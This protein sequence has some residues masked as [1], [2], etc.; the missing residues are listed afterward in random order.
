MIYWLLFIFL[1]GV[2]VFIHE[3]GHFT[4]AKLSG[5]KVER[6]AIGFGPV[7]IG[8][9]FGETEYAIC[10]LPLGGY[11]KMFGE[12]P[13]EEASDETIKQDPRSFAAK[14]AYTRIAVAAM[15]PI[16][17]LIL[18]IFIYM[19]TLLAIPTI[20]SEI[21]S[22]IPQSAASKAGLKAGDRVL[23]ING[24]KV[25]KWTEVDRVIADNPA[26]SLAV[27]V[28]REGSTES[29]T[30]TPK[31][32]KI[33]TPFGDKERGIAGISYERYRPV[34]GIFD[35][36][37]SAAK[38]GLQSG[39]VIVSV[40]GMTVESWRE[41]QRQFE[42]SPTPQ[43]IKVERFGENLTF[44]AP[45]ASQPK[46]ELTFN[47]P[48]RAS[49]LMSAGLETGD[50]YIRKVLPKSI[51]EEKGLKEGDRLV[52]LNG[53]ELASWYQFQKAIQG[54]KGEEISIGLLRTGKPL[55]INLVPNSIS[56][57]NDLTQETKKR[58]QLGVISSIVA[59]EP[60]GTRAPYLKNPLYALADGIQTTIE[61]ST[62]VVIG[63]SKIFTGQIELKKSLGGP[64]T[65]FY[66]AGDSYKA[67]GWHYFFRMMAMLSITLGL[68]N[69]LPIPVLD[70][71]HIF[72]FTI[73]ALKGSP[74]SLRVR[75]TAQQ[76]GM[77]LLLGLILL[78]FYVDISRYFERLKG[79]F[80]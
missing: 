45:L 37:L 31:R 40:N 49:T 44:D 7:L 13:E 65:I 71:G 77:V 22:V 53:K 58:R 72:F 64:I 5:I 9:T 48:R 57:K 14:S 35:P 52:S 27:V 56:E 66:L 6:F 20:T 23:S 51:A 80:S 12:E 47:F 70:G 15:G 29:L 19:G 34:V 78:T 11:V 16:A 60:S 46:K 39:D 32:E 10:A 18:P 26:T 68:I 62:L 75:E 33:Q 43:V 63:L 24:D 73:E 38:S 59:G 25:W 2:V 28:D 42:A 36:S 54:N 76:V 1:F 50:L 3:L 67:G 61:Q 74:V 41:F 30:L 21:G 55:E 4:V 69:I 79:I 17:N 8:K